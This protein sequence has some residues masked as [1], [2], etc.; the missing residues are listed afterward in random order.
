[1]GQGGG[2][3]GRTEDGRGGDKHLLDLH[4]GKAVGDGGVLLHLGLLGAER[5][6]GERVH[7]H[8]RRRRAHHLLPLFLLLRSNEIS[9]CG[10]P[11]V[12]G[13]GGVA[14]GTEAGGLWSNR[15]G[16]GEALRRVSV[17]ITA[18]QA[19]RVYYMNGRQDGAGHRN[20]LV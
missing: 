10:A 2:A 19:S 13:G 6:V 15:L 17:S 7:V 16:F 18:G 4:A 11:A 20:L 12:A 1:M 14:A 5:V 9:C 8:H 3:G